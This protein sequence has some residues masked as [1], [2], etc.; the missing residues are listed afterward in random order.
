[1]THDERRAF[2]RTFPVPVGADPGRTFHVLVAQGPDGRRTAT[3]KVIVTRV[4]FCRHSASIGPSCSGD[5][6]GGQHSPAVAGVGGG[7]E[8]S[9]V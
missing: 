5:S 1:M 2:A 8:S 6:G 7:Q 4:A 3:H 9:A